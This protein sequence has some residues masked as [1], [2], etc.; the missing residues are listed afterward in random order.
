MQA[1]RDFV[2]ACG[3]GVEQQLEGF[4][5]AVQVRVGCVH[6]DKPV[7]GVDP[8]AAVGAAAGVGEVLG[9]GF[10]Q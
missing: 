3:C 5:P 6:A 10:G 2:I 4:V 9:G 7:G 8:V 1:G